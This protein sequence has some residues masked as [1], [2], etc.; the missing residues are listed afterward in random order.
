MTS[1]QELEKELKSLIVETLILEDVTP[2]D[3]GT[4]MSLFNEGLGL[5]SIDALELGMA[6]SK[7]YKIK[8]SQDPEENRSYFA[9]VS[10]L[11]THVRNK[12]IHE[13]SLK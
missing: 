13:G 7:K 9:N 6:I 4:E 12:L 2:E 1:Q 5:D 3:I 11:A 8:M 10:S